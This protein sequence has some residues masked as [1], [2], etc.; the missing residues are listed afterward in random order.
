MM[1]TIFFL[2]STLFIVFPTTKN[3][4]TDGVYVKNSIE[5][6]NRWESIDWW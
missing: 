2:I 4:K 5:L 6:N 1:K 3:F